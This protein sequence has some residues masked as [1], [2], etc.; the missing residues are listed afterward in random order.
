[1]FA[2]NGDDLTWDDLLS[3]STNYE[4]ALTNVG[5]KDVLDLVP[6]LGGYYNNAGLY[7]DA[8]GTTQIQYKLGSGSL[9]VAAIDSAVTTYQGKLEEAGYTIIDGYDPTNEDDPWRVIG[10]LAVEIE[11]TSYNLQVAFFVAQD[12]QKNYYFIINPVIS[13]NDVE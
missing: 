1:M 11:G 13:V 7:A 4:Q 9:S 2:F 12:S 3:G 10:N 6:V 5:G 8:K